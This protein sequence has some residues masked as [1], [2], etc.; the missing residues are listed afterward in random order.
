MTT[1]SKGQET[2]QHVLYTT[3]DIINTKGYNST[4]IN[5][6]IEATGVKKGNLYFH[7]SSKEDL[8]YEMIETA[9]LEYNKYLNSKTNGSDPLEKIYSIFNAIYRFHKK[10][11]FVGGCLFGNMALELSDTNPRFAKLIDSIFEVWMRTFK[12]LLSEAQKDKLIGPHCDIDA[13]TIHIVATLEGAI[14]LSRTSKNKSRF[15]QGID[16]IKFMLESL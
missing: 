4:S 11:N 16:S 3:M 6:I 5:D 8:V 13:L 15:L 12:K 9:A 14:M 10:K 1:A 2:K 7:F